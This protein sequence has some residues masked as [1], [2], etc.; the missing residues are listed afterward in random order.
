MP[1]DS[2]SVV[3]LLKAWDAGDEANSIKGSFEDGGT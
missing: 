2:C 3:D 1:E